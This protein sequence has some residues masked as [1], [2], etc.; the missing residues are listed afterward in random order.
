M[1]TFCSTSIPHNHQQLKHYKLQNEQ[2]KQEV[3][4]V[5]HREMISYLRDELKLR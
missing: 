1:K 3:Y 4:T 5:P 2:N